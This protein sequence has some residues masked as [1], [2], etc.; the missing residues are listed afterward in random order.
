MLQFAFSAKDE[1]KLARLGVKLLVLFGSQAQKTAKPTSDIDVL[2]FGPDNK[3]VY[4]QIYDLLEEKIK[5]LVDI[6][7]VFSSQAP[8]ELLN[9]AS[10]YGRVIYS[11]KPEDFADFRQKVMLDYSDF[12]P[13]RQ[14]FQQATLQRI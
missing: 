13:Y 7:I 1:G 4:D 10:Q 9:H 5:R 8:L 12:V 6:D 11:Q 14:I 2:V 3:N